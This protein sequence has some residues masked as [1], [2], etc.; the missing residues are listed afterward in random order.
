VP[1]ETD[2]GVCGD[3]RRG[4]R[5]HLLKTFGCGTDGERLV[6]EASE[7]CDTNDLGG[8]TCA[9]LGLSGDG[10]RCGPGCNSFDDSACDA[11]P[12]RPGVRCAPLGLRKRVNVHTFTVAPGGA[13]GLISIDDAVKTRL[14][15]SERGA[16]VKT[17][18]PLQG[19]EP[20]W[21]V[22]LAPGRFA[23]VVEEGSAVV[24]VP[25]SRDGVGKPVELTRQ[26]NVR[27][28]AATVV[29]GLPLVVT[30]V[31][32]A[33][34]TWEVHALSPSGAPVPLPEGKTL[35]AFVRFMP[36]LAVRRD[37]TG[38]TTIVTVPVNGGTCVASIPTRGTSGPPRS[39]GVT[40]LETAALGVV[41]AAE[42]GGRCRA[43]WQH[44]DGSVTALGSRPPPMQGVEDWR[45]DGAAWVGERHGV[46][47]TVD[48]LEYR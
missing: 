44:P 10:L 3:G 29:E 38:V 14:I 4:D 18:S 23:Y 1:V 34:D 26:E 8:A 17:L 46:L 45:R 36:E 19:H 15:I 9:S 48:P 7:L 31:A 27:V 28:Q 39:Q 42:E 6:C 12:R 21:L 41:N 5:C 22:P 33:W 25:F 11:C 35:V 16:V 30:F 43:T 40:H 24:V 13:V 2:G 37:A 32:G 20:R 47:L